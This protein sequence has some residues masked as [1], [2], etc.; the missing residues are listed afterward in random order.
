M[1]YRRKLPLA[2]LLVVMIATPSMESMALQSSRNFA[3]LAGS[4]ITNTGPT[5]IGGTAGGDVGLSP[6]T[7]AAITG[8]TTQHVNGTIYTVDA[9]GPTGSVMDPDLL[10]AAKNDLV[11]AY[12]D[13][14]G[15]MYDEI[16]SADLNGRTLTGSY[17]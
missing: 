14:A 5:T 10:T 1:A 7:G 8:L 4:A 3:I 12:N 11:T 2:L 16:I 9:A 13:A 17:S 15:R 6:E